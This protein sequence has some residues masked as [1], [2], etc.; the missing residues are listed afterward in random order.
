MSAENLGKIVRRRLGT[1]ETR[2]LCWV[3][4]YADHPT[5]GLLD[6]NGNHITWAVH[7]CDLVTPEQAIQY[8]KARALS[9]EAK[10][11]NPHPTR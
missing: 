6:E 9:A 11:V 7:L 2:G 3:Q 10:L 5:Y 4:S 1:G 8:W